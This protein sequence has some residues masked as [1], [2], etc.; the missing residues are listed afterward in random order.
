[1]QLPRRELFPDVVPFVRGRRIRPLRAVRDI[2]IRLKG[3]RLFAREQE[4][5]AHFSKPGA[6]EF[7]VEQFEYGGHRHPHR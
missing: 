2:V 1:M 4:L 3:S 7:L 5:L 6:T